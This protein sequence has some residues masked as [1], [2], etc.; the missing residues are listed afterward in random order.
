MLK[1]LIKQ[2]FVRRLGVP[3]QTSSLSLLQKQGF[4][5]KTVFDVG[6]YKGDFV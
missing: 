6:A 4:T 2:F 3:N 1:K 5:P